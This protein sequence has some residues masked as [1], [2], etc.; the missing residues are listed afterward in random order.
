MIDRL[1]LP[2]LLAGCLVFAAVLVVEV[3]PTPAR[4]KIATPPPPAPSASAGLPLRRGTGSRYDALSATALARPLF[5]STRR[6]P[7]RGS[8]DGAADLG[9][10]DTRL[11]GIVIEPGRRIAIFAPAGAK[12]MT[13]SEG[14]TVGGWRIESITPIEVS[15]SGPGGIKT[16]QPKFDPNLVPAAGT[17]PIVNRPANGPGGA[18]FPSFSGSV[19]PGVRPGLPPIF[20]RGPPRPGL[21][22]RP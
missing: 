5:S 11:T 22:G 8:T 2:M 19:R 21:R 16:L 18:P 6:P 7:P 17:P 12:L 9:L 4:S 13:V 1:L 20:N 3:E 10:A 14:E 15:L